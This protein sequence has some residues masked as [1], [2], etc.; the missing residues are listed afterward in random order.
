MKRITQLTPEQTAAMDAHADEW[1][2][3]G[4][5]TQPADWDLFTDA[6]ERCYRHAGLPWHGRVVRVSSPLA[7]SIAAPTAAYVLALRQ[8][9]D[10]VDG[11]V[12]GAVDGAV[13]GAVYKATLQTIQKLY[14][15]RLWGNLWTYWQARNSFFRDHCHLELDGD[16][17]DRARAY[18]DTAKAAGWWWP[19]REFVMVCDRP[20]VLHLEQVGPRGWGS[21]RMHCET[22]PAI[23]WRDGYA[24]HYWH[25]VRV[26]AD[27]VEG[28][29]W[30]TDRILREPNAEIRRCA[31]EKLGWDRFVETANLTQ[32]GNRVADPGNPGH[33]IA[34]FDVPEQIYDEPVRVLLCTN[35]TEERDGTRRRFGLTVPASICDPV[36]AAAWT[37]G[38]NPSDYAR[39]QHA[40]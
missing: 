1:I 23:A 38:L 21:H 22:G 9:R 18:E 29:G 20:A 7:L 15:Y 28:D 5:S 10:A 37:F 36:A 39:L 12:N 33:T 25:G 30:D 11:A 8:L 13:D 14:Y 27:L 40:S 35:A 19:H 16:M 17:W 32:V 2:A 31:I 3:H 4:W 24:L 34:L 26:P 6:A